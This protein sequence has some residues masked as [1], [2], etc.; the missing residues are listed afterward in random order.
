M[1]EVWK[2]VPNYEGLYKVSNLGN[3]KS[4]AFGK[5]KILKG[6]K[7]KDGYILIALCGEKRTYRTAHQLV[8]MAFLGHVPNGWTLV[9]NH[10]NFNRSD[11]RLDNLEILTHREN[12]SYRKERSSSKFTGVTWNKKVKK[13]QVYIYK[14]DVHKYIGS[15][16]DE[17]KAAEAYKEEF[18]KADNGK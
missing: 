5:E 11:N 13:W 8:A 10:K 14:N 7:N 6:S 18:K 12:S 17:L 15:F 9:V 2:D 3:V 16:T 4:L 1:I